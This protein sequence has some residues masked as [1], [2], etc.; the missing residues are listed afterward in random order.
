MQKPKKE[1]REKF[2]SSVSGDKLMNFMSFNSLIIFDRYLAWDTSL[3]LKI[4]D[5]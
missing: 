5:W 1:K 3:P 2:T 4:H